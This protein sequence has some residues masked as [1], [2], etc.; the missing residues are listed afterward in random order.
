M[1]RKGSPLTLL[2]GMQ[3]STASMENSVEIPKKKLEIELPYNPAIWAYTPRKPE[4][5]VTG[6][7]QCSLQHCLQQLGRGSN[8]GVHWQTNG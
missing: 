5:K 3:A 1:W 4:L 7:P 6:V 2:V 8:L